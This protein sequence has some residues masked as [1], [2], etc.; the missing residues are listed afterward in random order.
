MAAKQAKRQVDYRPAGR[1]SKQTCGNCKSMRADGG[2]VKVQG[3]VD[4]KHVCDLWEAEA[5]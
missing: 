2:C 4:P 3:Q 5:K 1:H